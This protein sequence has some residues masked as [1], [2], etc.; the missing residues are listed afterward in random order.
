MIANS[1]WGC[2]GVYVLRGRAGRISW[3][4]SLTRRDGYGNKLTP[5]C[6]GSSQ[7][8][9]SFFKIEL[10]RETLVNKIIWVT[11]VQ[12]YN[13][14]SVYCIV[15]LPS[16]SPITLYI[17]FTLSYLLPVPFLSGNH[18][19]IAYEKFISH[20]YSNDSLGQ[21]RVMM[22]TFFFFPRGVCST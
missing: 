15:C 13:T 20:S 12:F 19:T 18:H 21:F 11:G 16:K 22:I 7:K 1:V 3:N 4:F 5:A 8:F 10:I 14:S 17:P 2:V 9:L 6:N